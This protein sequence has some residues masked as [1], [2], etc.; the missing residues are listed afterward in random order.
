MKCVV[1]W[2]LRYDGSAAENEASAAR[3]LEVYSKWTQ[4]SETTIHQFVLRVDGQ[5]GFAIQDSED[6][7]SLALSLA[8]LTPYL[9]VEVFPVLDVGEAMPL[10]TEA[11]EFRNS[12]K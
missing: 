5:G 6:L 7:A 2:K 9:E 3:A 12:V 1:A 11:I 8:K 4:A 10:V